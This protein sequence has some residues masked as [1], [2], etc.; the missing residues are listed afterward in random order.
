[1]KYYIEFTDGC[2]SQFKSKKAFKQFSERTVKTKRVFFET[3]HGRSKSDGLGG[4]VKS[5][6]LSAVTS[7]DAVIRDCKEI[8]EFCD[9]VLTVD[10]RSLDEGIMMNRK[11]YEITVEEIQ[12]YRDENPVKNYYPLPE[13]LKVHQINN[14]LSC[15]RGVYSQALA[16]CCTPCM[17][18]TPTSCKHAVI[19]GVFSSDLSSIRPKW[20]VFK[21]KGAGRSAGKKTDDSPDDDSD[22]DEEGQDEF[23]DVDEVE[24][25]REGE[26]YSML[27]EGDIAVIRSGDEYHP[28]YLSKLDCNPFETDDI[29]D[30]YKHTFPSHH[31]VIR[32]NYLESFKEIRGGE[33]YLETRFVG[34]V[35]S[36]YVVGICPD[37]EEVAQKRKGAEEIMLLVDSEIHQALCELVSC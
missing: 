1:M 36:L 31:R 33:L 8:M 29:T 6:C 35:S 30:D 27:Q 16:C 4:V 24:N 37:L 34:L 10:N 17:E 9:T 15:S 12:K 26:A 3:A 21:E 7:G 22:S 25:C 32:G 23:I 2:G 18:D 5:Y 19:T 28:Y 14:K 20:N 11:F 13:T